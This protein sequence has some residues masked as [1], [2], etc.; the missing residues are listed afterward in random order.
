MSNDLDLLSHLLAAAKTAGADQS[1]AM[2]IKGMSLSLDRRGG[3]V[4]HIER[5][6]GREIGLRVF[7]GQRSAIVSASATD[8]AGFARIA[9]QAV[10]MAKLVPEDEYSFIPTASP[11]PDAGFLDLDDPEEPAVDELI[12]RATLAEDAALAVAGVTNSEGASAGWGRSEVA[13]LTSL[14]FAAAYASSGHSI[15]ASAIAGAGVDMQRDYYYSGASHASDLEDA[16]SIGRRAGEQ[17]VARLNPSCPKTGRMSVVYHPRVA[18]SILGHF[19]S[20][21]NGNAIAR[22]TSFLKDKMGMRIFAPGIRII[23]DPLRVRGSRSR[24]CDGEGQAVS[25]LSLIEDG[26]LQ[27]WVLDCRS[28]RQL[29]LKTTGHAARGTS[30]PPSPSTSNLYLAAG[31]LSPDEL[32]ADIGEGLFIT[33]LIGM[34]INGLTGDYSRGASGF[35]IRNG[36]IAEPVA[37]FTIAGNLNDMFAHLTPANDLLLRRGTESP[38]IRIEGLMVAGA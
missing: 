21:I 14:G 1:D 26:I 17:A 6:E 9:E 30:G 28:A 23:D 16:A 38:T 7:V 3:K 31:S 2:Y 22:Q 36:A 15:S 8:P 12:R 24:P 35:M 34:G 13:L 4:E 27:S 10:S 29:G 33:E 25:T 37:E 19:A 32:M 18:T 11:A 20:A 5:A